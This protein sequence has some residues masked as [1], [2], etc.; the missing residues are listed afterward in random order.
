MI[1]ERTKPHRKSTPV[2]RSAYYET[3]AKRHGSHTPQEEIDY[4]EHCT[5]PANKCK[6][7]CNVK[8]LASKNDRASVGG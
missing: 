3:Q 8:E 7:K 2:A 4:C 1:S 5:V 6:G